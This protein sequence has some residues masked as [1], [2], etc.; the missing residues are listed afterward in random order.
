MRSPSAVRGRAVLLALAL[1]GA[2][3]ACRS[4]P[5]S[6]PGRGWS[7]RGHASWYG[8]PFHGRQTASGEIYDMHELTAAHKKLPFHSVVEVR[9]LDNG[10]TVRVRITDRG[11]FVK[12]RII[13]LSYAAAREIDMIGSGIA[14]VEI[15]LVSRTPRHP[16]AD[17]LFTVQIGAFRDR[18]YAEEL[19]GRVADG[20]SA[21]VETE[22]GWHRVRVGE[23]QREE[24][25]RRVR[26]QLHRAGHRAIVVRYGR[27]R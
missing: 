26:D 9:N 27:E 7:Q 19:A 6:D 1:A 3:T 13:D 15:R 8:K 25:A 22:G 12:G 10:R 24:A 2:V 17:L 21:R 23:F 5:A 18:R 11:P 16:A 20:L 14:P 4:G